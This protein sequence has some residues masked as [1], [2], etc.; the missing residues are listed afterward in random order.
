MASV[1]EISKKLN[2]EF[3]DDTL[4]IKADITPNYERLSTGAFGLD[5]PLY[6]GLVYGRIVTFA[7]LAHS[8]K[9]TAACLALAAYQR[10][11]SD[12]TCVYVD[13][14]HSLDIKF[15][16][17]MTGLDVD[18]MIYFNPKTLSGEQILDSIR[19]YQEGDDIGMIVLD[20]LPALLPA[21]VLENDI[22]KDLGM[23]GTIAKPLHKF[24]IAMSNL[25][26]QKGNILILINQVRIA[27]VAYNGAP[28][29]K[30]PCGDAP[31]YYSSTKVRF[32]TRTFIKGDN[33]DSSNGEGAEGFRLKFVVTKNKCAPVARGGGF[34]SFNYQKGFMWLDDLLEIA[35]KFDFIKRINNITYSLINLNTGEI[36][37]DDN[38][39]ELTGK[40]KDLETYIRDNIDF[41]TK[42]VDMLT[43]YITASDE[44]YGE[45]LDERAKEE[46][47]NQER[48]I[49]KNP[50]D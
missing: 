14:E 36:Y 35:Y 39:K 6:G 12:K 48:A 44:S 45:V 50:N 34:L 19:E 21:Q 38:G 13:V 31:Q 41:Q 9:T 5:Y 20:S 43:K 7:G 18:K 49:T 23:R 28:I 26:N 47:K 8:G 17:K 24:L 2:K 40:R 22:E 11:H 46:I 33:V 37:K 27:G 32:G 4:A 3:Q 1:L 15:Q 16:S 29:Y 42:Y 30:E 25:V 10:K